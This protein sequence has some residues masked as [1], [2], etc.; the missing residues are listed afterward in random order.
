[1]S[2][3]R[4]IVIGGGASGLIAAGEAAKSGAKVFILEKMRQ[5][6]RKILISG[7]GRCNI[8]NTLKT[9]ELIKRFGKNG[10][11]L[12]QSLA[13]F[14]QIDV[15]QFFGDIGVET[16]EERGG[17]VFP[18]S[19]SAKE[20]VDALVHWNRTQGV[21]IITGAKVENLII[22]NDKITGVEFSQDEM[23]QTKVYKADSV[24]VATGG[25]SYAATGSSGDGYKFAKSA[26]HKL[27]PLRPSLVPLLTAGRIAQEL[28]GLSLKNVNASLWIDDKKVDEEF[29]EMLFTHFGLSGP[30]ILTLSR[31]AV[32]FVENNVKVE[33]SIDLKPAL[34]YQKLDQRLLRDLSELS[35][36]QF[37]TLLQGLLPT[38]L[39]PV[40][41]YLLKIEPES[42]CNQI[43]QSERKALKLWLK[44]FRFKITGHRSFKEAIVTAGGVDLKDINPKTQ[45][46]KLVEGLFFAGEVLDLDGDTGGFNLQ[47]AFSTGLVAG[48]SAAGEEI[49]LKKKSKGSDK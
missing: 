33:I 37:K 28:Q 1:M 35:R 48:K 41:S 7:K 18:V 31:K 10:K 46:S 32:E 34:D 39:I 12:R 43:T 27:I 9:S 2:V 20:V 6:G 17:R 22:E 3:K 26:G 14:S 4:V 40:C 21:E 8:T 15:I 44:D 16:K 5:V 45:E 13:R 49:V 47:A 24:I 30:I 23:R 38:K 25:L 19:D 11:F 36:K 42:E 29:G